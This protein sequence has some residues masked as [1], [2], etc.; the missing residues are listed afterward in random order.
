MATSPNYGWSEPDNTSLVKDGA[1]AIRTLGNAID[2]SLWNNGYGQAGKNK[3]ING[4]FSV[5]Q[6][7]FTSIVGNGIGFDRFNCVT[8]GATATSSA[9]TFTLGAAPVAGYESKNFLRWTVTTG[10]DNCRVVQSIES[11]RT[12]AGQ[13]ATLSFYAKGTNPTTAGN[14]KV[15]LTQNFGTGGSPSAGVST[16]E[17]TFVLTGNWT[18]YSF[19]FPVSSITG[20][21]LGTNNDDRLEINIGQ[22]TNTSADAW[23]LDLWGVQLEYGSYA[24]P[25]QTA[26]G[27]SIQGELAMCQRYL[28]VVN[29]AAILNGYAYGT[30]TA[31]YAVPFKVQARVAPTGITTSGNIN[32]HALNVATTVTPTL[33][34]GSVDTASL[35]AS[36]T[37]TAGQGSRIEMQSGSLILFTGCE[38]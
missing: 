22:G 11:V 31:I 15:Y 7:N 8:S 25:F 14:L 13:T 2:T 24:S 26:S 33:N 19:I 34:I 9:Q 38:L 17:Q 37:I 36:F 5:N 32:A 30:N 12:F 21:T 29:A 18:R 23:T 28:P 6:R 35:L 20:K 1:L 27:G 3:I 16:A 4:D 10:N